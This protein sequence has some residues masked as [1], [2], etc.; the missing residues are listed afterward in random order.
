MLSKFNQ[1]D[2]GNIGTLRKRLNGITIATLQGKLM[3][4]SGRNIKETSKDE[5][6]CLLYEMVIPGEDKPSIVE[7]ADGA[8]ST[9]EKM[10]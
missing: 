1:S 2:K 4:L 7:D 10:C 6:H 9:K 8:P 5:M 3:T